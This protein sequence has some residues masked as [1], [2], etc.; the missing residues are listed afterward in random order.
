MNDLDALIFALLGSVMEFLPIVFPSWFPRSGADQS[1]A[2]ALWLGVMGATQ[3][4]IGAGYVIRAHVVPA[5][6]RMFSATPGGDRSS[7]ALSNSRAVAG[8]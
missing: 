8:R 4:A 3:V 2:R 1:S 7:V 6:I 5:V